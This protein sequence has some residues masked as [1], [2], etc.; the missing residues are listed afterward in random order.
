MYLP[1]RGY[2]FTIRKTWLTA[3]FLLFY[4]RNIPFYILGIH[5][6]IRYIF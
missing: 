6:F 2:G 4:Y 5:D 1:A 3:R